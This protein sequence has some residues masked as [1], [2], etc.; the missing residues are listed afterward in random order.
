MAKHKAFNQ[1]S[2]T[3]AAGKMRKLMIALQ[4]SPLHEIQAIEPRSMV[5]AHR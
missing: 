5:N 4:H 3:L 2:G 1:V